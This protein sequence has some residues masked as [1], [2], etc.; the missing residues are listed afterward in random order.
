MS[1]IDEALREERV[2]E[3]IGGVEH[4][5]LFDGVLRGWKR[6]RIVV[7]RFERPELLPVIP[8]GAVRMVD[9]AALTDYSFDAELAAEIA[10]MTGSP[11]AATF[12]GDQPVSFCHAGAI[13][14]TYW[15]IGVDTLEAHWGKGYAGLCVAHLIHHMQALGK[16][17]VWQAVEEN[18][19]SMRVAAK[20]GFEPIDELVLYERG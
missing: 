5:A 2:T 16:A 7:F 13:G 15:D 10:D 6:S 12:L 19:A 14:E 3:V 1:A 18:A 9:A 4:A 17:P 8:P 20:L 11:I